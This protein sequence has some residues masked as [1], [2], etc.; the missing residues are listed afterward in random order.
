VI[1]AGAESTGEHHLEQLLRAL[2]KAKQFKSKPHPYEFYYR[3]MPAG[4]FLY[5]AYPE[6]EGI[7]KYM[8]YR[9]PGHLYLCRDLDALNPC[10]CYCV[11][12]DN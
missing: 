12:R 8:P 10:E 2:E 4:Y 6:F 5:E 3:D 1:G 9:S 11:A 7:Y